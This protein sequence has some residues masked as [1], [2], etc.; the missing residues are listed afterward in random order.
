MKHLGT[1]LGALA[2]ALL[3]NPALAQQKWLLSSMSPGGSSNSALFASWAKRVADA[4]NGALAIEIKDGTSLASFVNVY[5][6]VQSDVLQVGWTFHPMYR[7]KWP[8]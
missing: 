6:R 8:L 2:F 1:L 4:S 7:D 3:A 5:E